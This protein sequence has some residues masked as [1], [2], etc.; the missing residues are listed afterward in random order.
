[1]N[2]LVILI[3]P[4]VSEQMGGEA[5]KALQTFQQ[6]SALGLQVVQITH[7]RNRSELT[8]RLR[9]PNVLFVDDGRLS[10][11]LWKSYVFRG[12]L[13]SWFSYKAVRLAER[14]ASGQAGNPGPVIIHQTEPNSPVVPRFLSSTYINVFG[15]INGNINYPETFFRYERWSARLRRWLHFPLQAVN[16]WLPGAQA[17]RHDFCGW[18]RPNR[19][20]AAGRRLPNPRDGGHGGLWRQRRPA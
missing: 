15:P 7:G 19:Q 10:V 1:M 8:D 12:L 11:F 20:V 5:I 3:A 9:L 16:R 14:F 17:C 13:D 6:A 18:W 4:N 2:T